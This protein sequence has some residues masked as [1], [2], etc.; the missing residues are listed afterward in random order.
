MHIFK[1]IIWCAVVFFAILWWT[2]YNHA[3][4]ACTARHGV[5]VKVAGFGDGWTGYSCVEVK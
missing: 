4:N 2:N 3:A 1:T 5:M